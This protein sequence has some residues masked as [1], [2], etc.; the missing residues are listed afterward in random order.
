M[1]FVSDSGRKF[2]LHVCLILAPAFAYFNYLWFSSRII[3]WD[4][5][6]QSDF[7]HFGS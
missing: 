2:H 4:P 5:L 7:I 6:L 3:I 1:S